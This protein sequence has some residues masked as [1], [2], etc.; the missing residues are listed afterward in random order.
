MISGVQFN[1]W[2]WNPKRSHDLIGRVATPPASTIETSENWDAAAR[3]EW[4]KGIPIL[5]PALR[6][7]L[8]CTWQPASRSFRVPRK[9]YLNKGQAALSGGRS[10]SPQLASRRNSIPASAVDSTF[11]CPYLTRGYTKAVQKPPRSTTHPLYIQCT[12]RTRMVSVPSVTRSVM[13]RKSECAVGRRGLNS[14]WI[15]A[16]KHKAPSGCR[17][18]IAAFWISLRPK[19]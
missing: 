17:L 13:S 6:L 11:N 14:S 12:Q 4:R 16:S 19:N 7:M 18:P 3:L 2:A 8:R 10:T 9:G 15:I 1:M 5:G